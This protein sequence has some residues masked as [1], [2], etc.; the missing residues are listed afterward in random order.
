MADAFRRHAELLVEFLDDEAHGCRD[1]RK[2][3]AWYFKGY[4][5]GG[6]TRA[7]LSTADS[8]ARIDELLA[9]LDRD[10]PYPG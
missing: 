6:E 1:I 4:A 5:V 8:F 10:Q 7:A 9:T 2:H 3:V